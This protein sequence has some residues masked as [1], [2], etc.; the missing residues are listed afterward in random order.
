MK[1][2]KEEGEE[3]KEKQKKKRWTDRKRTSASASITTTTIA[4]ASTTT[5][6]TTTLRNRLGRLSITKVERLRG[7][8]KTNIP[9]VFHGCQLQRCQFIHVLLRCQG[10]AHPPSPQHG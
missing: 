10:L 9:E 3:E 4:A 2:E 5:T 7:P 8:G 1:N 6:T